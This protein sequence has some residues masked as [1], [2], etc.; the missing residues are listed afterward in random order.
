MTRGEWRTEGR[1]QGG[2]SKDRKWR[3]VASFSV[4]STR[5]KARQTWDDAELISSERPMAAA[6]DEPPQACRCCCCCSE[7]REYMVTAPFIT[8][9]TVSP[10]AVVCFKTLV[11]SDMKRNYNTFV[12]DKYRIFY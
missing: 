3:G 8:C 10:S 2:S 4:T 5:G 6:P 12:N 9:V 7:P 1:N 11:M